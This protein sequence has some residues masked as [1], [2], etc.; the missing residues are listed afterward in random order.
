M[1]QAG[2]GRL[3]CALVAS[4]CFLVPATAAATTTVVEAE[5]M[6]WPD[7]SGRV[8]GDGYQNWAN[9]W[10]S[11]TVDLPLAPTGLDVRVR[12]AQRSLGSFACRDNPQVAVR[13]DG[14]TVL[15][16]SVAPS[17]TTYRDPIVDVKR[18][19]AGTHRIQVGLRNNDPSDALFPCSRWLYVDKVTITGS[20][21]FSPLSWRNQQLAPDAPLDGDQSAVGRL[22]QQLAT[23]PAWV[24]TR[25]W[26]APIY[27]ASA[28]QRRVR[29]QVETD[30]EHDVW[31]DWG[32]V[33][34]VSS[35][36]GAPP[37]DGYDD[38]DP[39]WLRLNRREY[40]DR[41]LIVYQPATDSLWEFIHLVKRGGTFYAADGGKI[42]NVSAS[43][44][45]WDPWPSGLPHG[46]TAAG[47]PHM[48]GMQTIA[49]VVGR[50]EIDHVVSMTLPHTTDVDPTRRNPDY[51]GVRPPATRSDGDRNPLLYP[52]AIAEG[53]RF[54]L[55]GSLDLD[56][57]GLTAYGKI[58]ARAVQ[59]Y[60]AV[61]VDRSCA[62][63][64]TCFG[65]EA[66][67]KAAVAFYAEQP[68]DMSNDPWR[69]KFGSRFP[70]GALANFPWDKLEVLP[71]LTP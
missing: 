35:A 8:Y 62:L 14:T 55:P 39:L 28:N 16:S 30:F 31:R 4:A 26:S 25:E 15:S 34:L 46:T 18:I 67:S 24:N 33:P 49:E 6:Q 64:Q 5:S 56:S 2:K 21:L 52:D 69:Q 10:G 22:G 17:S 9:A 12:S 57:L 29:V 58:L 50:G 51:A 45:T 53:T 27:I 68:P 19:S 70:N 13:I 42:T 44:G 3:V 63:G 65:P 59:R 61:V 38:R 20:T 40:T 43:L 48:V 36:M 54:R 7:G 1:G 23:H 66:E 71:P 41:S 11:A 47:I 37:A 60:G 32:D